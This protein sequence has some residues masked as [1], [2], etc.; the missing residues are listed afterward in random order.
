MLESR[1][2]RAAREPKRS[3]NDIPKSEDRLRLADPWVQV[4]GALR[5]LLS[6]TLCADLF[7][8][9]AEQAAY[10][11]KAGMLIAFSW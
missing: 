6:L 8:V 3:N 7:A 11:W 2:A 9:P 10:I 1:N 4:E 5:R